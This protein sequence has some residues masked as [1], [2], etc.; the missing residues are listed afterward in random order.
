VETT[1]DKLNRLKDAQEQVAQACERGEMSEEQYRAFQREIA[2]TESKLKHFESQLQQSQSSLKEFG[3]N[4]EKA[5]EKMKEVGDKMTSAGK[6]L[7]K[8]VTAP[9][10]G[11]GAIAVKVGSDFEAGMSQVAAVSGASGDELEA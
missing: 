11:I 1:R 6:D 4:M 9:L 8:K 3:D 5:G 2:E 10:M 7:T